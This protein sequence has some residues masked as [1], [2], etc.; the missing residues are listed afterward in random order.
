MRI[1]ISLFLL[2]LPA[3]AQDFDQ[4]TRPVATITDSSQVQTMLA[5][6]LIAPSGTVDRAEVV[7]FTGNGFGPDDLIILHPSLESFLVGSDV[8]A[9]LQEAMK[10]WELKADYRLDATLDDS[11]KIAAD[12][13][14]R[15]DAKA[16][17]MG[18]VL[19][20][21]GQYY[22]G[23]VMD[24]RLAQDSLGVRLEMWNY[25]P[26]A[27]QYRMPGHAAIP[28]PAQPPAQRFE[29][30]RPRFVL[31]FRDPSDCIEAMRTDSTMVTRPC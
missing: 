25:D 6:L 10:T 5:E 31:A 11:R 7:D 14:R 27:L 3:S 12:A 28:M 18:S 22:E 20:A 29:F 4:L 9:T 8:P 17:L 16:A 2:A 23:D 19:S 24:M 26:S 1:P 21:V 15:Q 30:A 13:H